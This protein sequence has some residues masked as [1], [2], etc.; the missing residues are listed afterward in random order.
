M[1]SKRASFRRVL[2]RRCHLR[3]RRA[4]TNQKVERLATIPE[5]GDR[6]RKGSSAESRTN[7]EEATAVTIRKS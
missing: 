7:R 5:I 1:Q 6:D 2:T 4:R 3:A